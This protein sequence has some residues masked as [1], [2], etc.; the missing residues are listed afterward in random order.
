MTAH[1]TSRAVQDYYP[2]DFAH[3][4]GCGRLNSHGHQI[5]TR[6]EGEETVTRFTPQPFHVAVPGFVYGGLIASLMDCHGMATAAAAAERRAGRDIG[7]GPAPRYVTASLKV[8][9]LKPT[10]LGPEL[11]LRGS[12][13]D[14]GQRK[15]IVEV[16]LTVL[17]DVTARGEIVAVPVPEWM[18]QKKG[19]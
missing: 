8:D 13:K 17:N 19:A 2:D 16:T 6:W 4:F 12:V 7:E 3:C 11:E 15:I 10:P 14:M 5:K 18:M 9:F 1:P